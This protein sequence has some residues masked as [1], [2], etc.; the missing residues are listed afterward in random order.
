MARLVTDAAGS[1]ARL[2]DALLQDGELLKVW[3][4]PLAM[5]L[6]ELLQQAYLE[7][8]IH[9]AAIDVVALALVLEIDVSQSPRS[10]WSNG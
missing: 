9:R 10:D 6:L 3:L 4:A 1:L 8:H 2:A 5:V 7:V